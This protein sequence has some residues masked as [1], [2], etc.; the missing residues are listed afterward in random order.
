MSNILFYVSVETEVSKWL[1]QASSS[2]QGILACR[3][4]TRAPPAR[5]K[6]KK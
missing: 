4:D 3:A 1:S 5:M 2:S 6:L